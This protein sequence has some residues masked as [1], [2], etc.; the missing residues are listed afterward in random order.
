MK[1][2]LIYWAHAIPFEYSHKIWRYIF[3]LVKLRISSYKLKIKN[4]SYIKLDNSLYLFPLKF[5]DEILNIK[6]SRQG[7]KAI[8][9]RT[10]RHLPM[11]HIWEIN[12]KLKRKMVQK[13]DSWD[14]PST[15]S[16]KGKR[17]KT[18]KGLAL[19]LQFTSAGKKF[20]D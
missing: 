7:K 20:F 1:L 13:K 4:L 16:T 11:C 18:G 17:R 15:W 5:Q 12:S 3:Q 10:N 14:I 8:F 6:V 19:I 9:F 2:I